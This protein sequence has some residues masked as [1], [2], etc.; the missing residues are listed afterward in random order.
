[1]TTTATDTLVFVTE[2][3]TFQEAWDAA[4]ATK[5]D[6]AAFQGMAQKINYI[7]QADRWFVDMDKKVLYHSYMTNDGVRIVNKAET[8][9][10]LSDSPFQYI[11]LMVNPNLE[12]NPR[13]EGKLR[14]TGQYVNRQTAIKLSKD[15]KVF[16]FSK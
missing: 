10:I 13:R 15:A 7:K 6:F 8:Y 4:T 5:A 12:S 3:A 11:Q 1:M 16:A 2:F 9:S 14:F